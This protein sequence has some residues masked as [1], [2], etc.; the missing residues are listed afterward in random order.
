MSAQIDRSLQAV[1]TGLAK[2]VYAGSDVAS[3]Y[4]AVVDAA[5]RLVPGC[6]HA[7]VTLRQGE[8]F[9]SAAASDDIARR[10]DELEREVGNGPCL[11]AITSE[12]Y[13]HDP[14]LL[15]GSTWPEL[16]RRTVQETPVRGM[17]GYRMVIGERKLGALNMFSDTP[18]ALSMASADIGAIIASFA[19]VTLVASTEH[20]RADELQSG[21]ESNRE[22]GK[23]I[24]LLMAAHDIDD[25]QAFE[26]LRRASSELNRKLVDIAREL[27]AKHVR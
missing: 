7:C 14:D 22:I 24:G 15:D 19:S 16:A 21:L 23:A 11:D 27:V 9:T 4:Q 2:L 13:Q 5:V 20:Q 3:V 25:A 12:A 6:D 17:V 26:V 8:R 1:F 10:V 18:G